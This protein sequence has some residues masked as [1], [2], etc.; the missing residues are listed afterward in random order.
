MM[1]IKKFGQIDINSIQE[2]GG[3]GASLGEMTQ[4]GLP[5]PPGYCITAGAYRQFVSRA[6]LAGHLAQFAEPSTMKN[7]DITLLAQEISQRILETPLPE[8]LAQEIVQAFTQIIG[9]GSLAA[10]RSSATAED[11]PEASFAGQQESYLN[12]PRSELLNHIKQCWASLWT[13]RAIHYRINNGFDQRQVYLAVVVQQMVDSEVSGVAFSVNLM[14]AKENEMVIESVWGLGEGIV[15]GKVTPDHYVINKQND[16]LIRYVIADKEKMAV[17]PLHGS[18]TLFAEVAGDQR[19]RS[20]LSQKDILELTELIKRIEE[21]YQ[22]PQ[23]I[24]WAKTGNRYY[25]LQARPITTLDKAPVQVDESI[26]ES[27]FF[28]FDPE[29]EWTNL[30]GVKERYN[31]P[32]SVLGWSILEPCDTEGGLYAYRSISKKE[33]PS[34]LFAANIYGYLYLNFTSLKSLQPLKM[35]EPYAAVPDWQQFAP[36]RA[37]F[38][39]LTLT[40]GSIKA[41]NK[42]IKSLAKDFYAMLPGYLDKIDKYK[43]QPGAGQTVLSASAAQLIG[44]RGSLQHADRFHEKVAG[45]RGYG[46]KFQAGLRPA[47]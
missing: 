28:S 29:L 11:L 8:E 36:K 22:L 18:G 35:L 39:E 19:Q 26:G 47:R 41:G 7:E 25:I 34:P 46:L 43:K 45:R 33:L 6:G 32:S 37:W 38:Q 44:D 23:D 20:S 16:P 3:K 42:L 15:S 1:F 2:V 24:E 27:E 14:N 13:E 40:I 30:G 21:H 10:V 31:K 4:A 5:V 17:R 12:V 9:H